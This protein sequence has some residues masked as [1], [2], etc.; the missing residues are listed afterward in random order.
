[1]LPDCYSTAH[2]SAF[3]KIGARLPEA[4]EFILSYGPTQNVSW[5][6]QKAFQNRWYGNATEA[7]CSQLT[8]HF[9]ALFNRVPGQILLLRRFLRGPDSISFPVI[10][11]F[12]TLLA[13]PYY[14]W[15]ASEYLAERFEQHRLE[16]PIDPFAAELRR[17]LP[18][19]VGPGSSIRYAQNLMTALRDNGL[20]AGK[21]NKTIAGP[22]LTTQC[23]AYMLYALSDFG[24]GVNEFDGSP[25]HRSIIKP[26]EIFVPLFQ[27]G[28]RLGYWEFTGD[29]NRLS[30]NLRLKG[31]ERWM[32][33]AS[34]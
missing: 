6:A 11:H 20:L 33:A 30:A 9:M 8:R 16:V 25:L 19:S 26:R 12:Y 10:N 21:V 14:R 4:R 32:E 27:E 17:H 23:L 7:V 29:R 34:L 15:A 5:N 2:S 31:L 24:V 28:E 22:L 18:P 13:D 3:N 1:M